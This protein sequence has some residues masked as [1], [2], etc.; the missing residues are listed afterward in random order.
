MSE[1]QKYKYQL[2]IKSSEVFET[3]TGKLVKDIDQI[4]LFE[5]CRTAISY[6][7]AN[8]G[9]KSPEGDEMLFQIKEVVLELKRSFTTL[10]ETEPLLA[11][12]RGVLH[13]YGEYMGL[14][15]AVF[16]HFIRQYSIHNNRIDALKEF[17][18]TQLTERLVPT[19]EEIRSDYI[20]RLNELFSNYKAKKTLSAQ[21][22]T[23]YFKQLW[24]EH[25]I[26]FTPEVTQ[27]LKDQ[28][29]KEV[30]GNIDFSKAKDSNEAKAMKEHYQSIRENFDTDTRVLNHAK[31]LGLIK[32]FKMLEETGQNI[33]DLIDE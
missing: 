7:Y 32:W 28:A 33:N 18:K 13:E 25:I 27:G 4:D 3:L 11:I 17:T 6:G 19:P 22:C 21:E 29:L 26:V 8:A 31:Y 15:V 14:S 20:K 1:V 30:L 2:D 9:F 24:R 5:I 10:R 16:I 23:F 12:R